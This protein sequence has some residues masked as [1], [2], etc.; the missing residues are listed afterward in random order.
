MQ[1]LQQQIQDELKELKELQIKQGLDF[2]GEDEGR[3]QII[4]EQK[5]FL[6]ASNQRIAEGERRRV[7]EE[8]IRIINS[9]KTDERKVAS[10]G[11]WHVL[12]TLMTQLLESLEK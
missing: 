12:D 11:E 3:W 2:S 6:S 9:M 1:T 7:V 10:F 5:S 8:V 4:E